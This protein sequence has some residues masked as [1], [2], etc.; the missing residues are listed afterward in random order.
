MA[1]IAVRDDRLG[2]GLALARGLIDLRDGTIEVH[3]PGLGKGS[4]FI[5]H[6]PLT[7]QGEQTVSEKRPD[8][9]AAAAASTCVIADDNIDAAES[10]AMLLQLGGH[11]VHVA[12]DGE[13]ALH[14]LESIKPRF[15]PLDIGMPK[16]NGHQVATHIRAAPGE[17]R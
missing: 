10:P 12:N 1:V 4:E 7:A 11:E 17:N 2:V 14:L 13:S 5:V 8:T 9:A 3:S 15:A 6:L 16:M